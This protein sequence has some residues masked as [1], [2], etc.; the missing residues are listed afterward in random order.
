MDTSAKAR[1]ENWFF[2]SHSRAELVEW[3]ARMRFFRFCRAIGGVA[4]LVLPPPAGSD[5]WFRG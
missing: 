3:T 2:R 4:A 5:R 1:F